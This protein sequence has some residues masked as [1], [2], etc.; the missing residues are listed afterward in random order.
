MKETDYSAPRPEGPGN[1]PWGCGP[2]KLVGV[3]AELYIQPRQRKTDMYAC[4]TCGYAHGNTPLP[5][6][7]AHTEA[8]IVELIWN[9]LDDVGLDQDYCYCDTSCCGPPQYLDKDTAARAVVK[10]LKDKG[11]LLYALARSSG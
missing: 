8:E 5:D 11:L 10:M 7:P 4:R 1:C 3:T 9:A 2:L 6:E